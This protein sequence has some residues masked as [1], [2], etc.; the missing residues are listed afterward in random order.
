MARAKSKRQS[1]VETLDSQAEELESF[2]K[3]KAGQADA[4]LE[5]AIQ[6]AQSSIEKAKAARD[7]AMKDDE[8]LDEWEWT[9][10]IVPWE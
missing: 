7:L 3:R 8:P 5:E 9:L 6:K 1:L 2:I 10:W 4:K